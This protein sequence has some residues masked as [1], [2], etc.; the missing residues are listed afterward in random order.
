MLRTDIIWVVE[1]HSFLY[2]LHLLLHTDSA[3]VKGAEVGLSREVGVVQDGM[4]A[5]VGI[6][7]TAVSGT[8]HSLGCLR[9]R[10]VHPVGAEL[11]QMQTTVLSTVH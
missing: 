6:V 10:A 7:G 5:E 2:I 11:T 3:G 8:E 1:H 4:G 9:G